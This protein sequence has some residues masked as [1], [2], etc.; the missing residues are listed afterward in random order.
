MFQ[1]Y[2]AATR[3]VEGVHSL[4]Q[5]VEYY[6]ACLDWYL[7]V[8]LTPDDV[9]HLGVREVARIEGNIR[10]VSVRGQ[11]GVG[12]DRQGSATSGRSA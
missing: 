1:E 6:Q 7:G 4:P 8:R 12:R 11:A 5:G 9:F 3:P 10:K 2:T